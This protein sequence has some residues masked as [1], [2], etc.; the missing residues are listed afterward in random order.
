MT[1]KHIKTRQQA[2][3]VSHA[4]GL[5]FFVLVCG[6]LLQSRLETKAWRLLGLLLF[7]PLLLV[8]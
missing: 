5:T 7:L 6:Q 2:H 3:L 1:I 8:P 4:K